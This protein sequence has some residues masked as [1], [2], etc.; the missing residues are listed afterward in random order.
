MKFHGRAGHDMK[1]GDTHE[2]YRT[3]CGCRQRDAQ[4]A[5][6]RMTGAPGGGLVLDPD[7]RRSGRGAYLHPQPACWDAFVRGHPYV[8]SLRRRVPVAERRAA[9]GMLAEVVAAASRETRPE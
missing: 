3:C 1:G 7:R 6:R 5:L 4:T 2:P 9:V 8:Q